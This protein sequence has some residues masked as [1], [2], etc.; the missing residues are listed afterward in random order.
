LSFQFETSYSN[1]HGWL[2]VEI[3]KKIGML[4]IIGSGMSGLVCRETEIKLTC[5]A[6]D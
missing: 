5:Q 6:K 4:K 3:L 1:Y 2:K